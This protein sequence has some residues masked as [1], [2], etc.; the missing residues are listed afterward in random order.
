MVNSIETKTVNAGYSTKWDSGDAVNV[1][2]AVSGSN[3][4]VNDGKFVIESSQS[5]TF[6]GEL[7][8]ALLP[9]T[10]YDWYVYYPYSETITSPNNYEGSQASWIGTNTSSKIETQAAYDTMSHLGGEYFPM[11]GLRKS[12]LSNVMPSVSINHI[13]SL[14]DVKV[15]NRLD[16]A[17]TINSVYLIAPVEIIGNFT[18]DFTSDPYDWKVWTSSASK[19]VKCVIE[20]PGTLYVGE[21]ANFYIGV[22]PFSLSQEENISLYVNASDG[23]I[24]GYHFESYTPNDVIAFKAGKI[25]TLDLDYDTQLGSPLTKTTADFETFN[26]GVKSTTYQSYSSYDGWKVDNGCIVDSNNWD[27]IPS[28]AP[29]LNGRTNK[30]GILESPKIAGGCGKLSF[31]T[32]LPYSSDKLSIKVEIK[33]DEGTTLKEYTF[34]PESPSQKT[35]YSF[36]E[37]VNVSGVFSILITNLC[38]SNK[39]TNKDR[40][41]IYNL[42]WTN[43]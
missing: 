8:E 35:E 24:T 26:D 34:T 31:K 25:M 40:T 7:T 14:I 22:R 41:A 12:V 21:S 42:S 30:I 10:E 39:S 20:N 11:F 43:Y 16:K 17:I 1:F 29:C 9:D 37:D 23:E 2:H 4:Y 13:L 6:T 33:N 38:P 19:V 5:N 3:E 28:L 15:T 32:G 18:V 27:A 36:E